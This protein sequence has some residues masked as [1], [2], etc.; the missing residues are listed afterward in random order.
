MRAGPVTVKTS[1]EYR[2]LRFG[3]FMGR[4]KM[5]SWVWSVF[6]APV[7][8]RETSVEATQITSDKDLSSKCLY[9]AI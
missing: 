3:L 7:V 6:M 4:R 1:F 9:H 2:Q 5:F 8:K